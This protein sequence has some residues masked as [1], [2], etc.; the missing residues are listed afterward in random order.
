[1][2]DLYATGIDWAAVKPEQFRDD[3]AVREG[4]RSRLP[5]CGGKRFRAGWNY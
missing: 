3:E 2:E 4:L 1:M 5:T